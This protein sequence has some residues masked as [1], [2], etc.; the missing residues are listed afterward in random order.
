[1]KL[2]NGIYKMKE[3]YFSQKYHFALIINFSLFEMVHLNMIYINSP[4]DSPY[5][6]F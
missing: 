3:V 5:S 1:M 4:F 6:Y 2:L